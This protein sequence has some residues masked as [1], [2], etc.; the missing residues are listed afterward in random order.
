MPLIWACVEA[1]DGNMTTDQLLRSPSH[2][3]RAWQRLLVRLRAPSL[4][5]QLAAGWPPSA[6]RGL[7]LRAREITSPAGRRELA[8]WWHHVLMQGR[9]PPV[10]RTPLVLRYRDRIAGA[11]DDVQDMLAVLTG[12]LPVTA[13]GAAMASSLLRDGTGP[14][15]N[16]HSP[17]SLNDAVREATRQ[18]TGPPAGTPPGGTDRESSVCYR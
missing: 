8:Q 13:R 17:V 11:E 2:G 10:P 14:L 7:A 6:S 9:R 16:R 3:N 4:D 18:M 1:D 12:P 15:H 5:R